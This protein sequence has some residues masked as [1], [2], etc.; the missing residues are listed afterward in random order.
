[1]YLN[2]ELKKD[3]ADC[4]TVPSENAHTGNA[5]V[6]YSVHDKARLYVGRVYMCV[7]IYPAHIPCIGLACA[8][9]CGWVDKCMR[10][11]SHPCVT[12]Q[13]GQADKRKK[14]EEEDKGDE[15]EEGAEG[16]RR[17]KHEACSGRLQTC[18]APL[19]VHQS[20]LLVPCLVIW[21]SQGRC[22]ALPCRAVLKRLTELVH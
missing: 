21:L 20:F 1:M 8:V 15:G 4:V 11:C 7:Y 10:G 18:K 9:K 13:T 2:T 6:L 5:V 16:K 19:V 14:K 22:I 12:E 17:R 3:T